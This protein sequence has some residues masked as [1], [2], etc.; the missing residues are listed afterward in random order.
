MKVTDIMKE[1]MCF[2][3]EVFP[4][5]QDKPMEPLIETLDHL[6]QF[7]P[8]FISCTYG[9]GGSNEGRNKEVCQLIKST[10]KSIP[11][12]HF[13]CIGNKKDSIRESLQGYLDMGVNHILAMRGDFPKGWEE[14]RGDFDH[15]NQLVS[16]IRENYPE[17]CIA[18]AANPEKHHEA[19]TFEED[20]SHLRIKQ[21]AGG[22]YIMT[23]LCYDVDQYRWWVDKLRSA[24]VTIPIDVGVMPVLSMDSTVRMT[25]SNGS[26]VPRDL[27]EIMARYGDKAEEFKKAGKDY[28]VK[29]IYDFINA[30]ID[31]LH[32][33][34]LNKW[35]DVT[36]ILKDAGI[37]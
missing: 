13:T 24:K 8:D 21:D 23:Q 11:V 18:V 3:F 16:Y 37:V 27:A 10:G 22:Q 17:F 32:I 9:A 29:L 5:K 20:I 35:Q 34:A 7:S 26:A 33:Y 25:L 1:K 31:G 15:A 30:G 2:S 14:T 36:D 4:P 12:T 19:K 6:Y 28:T